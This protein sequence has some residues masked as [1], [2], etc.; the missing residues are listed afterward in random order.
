MMSFRILL[1]GLCIWGSLPVLGQEYRVEDIRIG[2]FVGERINTCIEYRVKSQDVEHLVEPFRHREETSLWQSEF[3]GKWLLGA[4]SSYEYCKDSI[5]LEQIKT[6]VQS[7][8][9]TQTSEGYIGNYKSEAQLTNWDIWGRKYSAL[10]LVAYYRL[11]GDKAALQAAMRSV[12]YLIKQLHEQR[13][14]I[15]RTGNYFGMASCSILE[16]VVY[17]YDITREKRYLDFAKNI[18]VGIE[19]KGS[20]QL[21]AKALK[22]VPVSQRSA[23]P[24]SWWSF[25]NGQKAYEMMSCYE[26]LIELGR[27]LNDPLYKEVAER[28]A[29]SIRQDE[30]NIA[31]SGAA[32][33]C[34][35]GG[36]GKQTLPAYHTMETCVTFTYMQFCNRLW[37]DT[38]NTLYIEEFER[39]MYNAL[40]ASMKHDGG[41]ISKYSPLEG[42]RLP[43]EEQCGMHINCCNANGPRG[44]ALIPKM[45]VAAKEDGV[46]FNLYVP[47]KVMLK[48]GKKN[49][50]ALKVAT[51]YPINGKVNIR[52]EPQRKEHFK[53]AL[54]I[55]SYVDGMKVFVNG[56]EQEVLH[57]GGYFYL[58][59]VWKRGDEVVLEFD[60]QTKVVKNHNHQAVVRGPLVFARDSRFGDGDV[61]EC[62][63]IQ[64]D[65][66]GVVQAT[67]CNNVSDSFAWITLEVPAVLGTDLEDTVNKTAKLVR[68]C[69]FASSG[70]DWTS[71][72][73]YRVWIP[74]TLHVMKEPYR[75]Y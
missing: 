5:L 21:I 16:P 49:A 9:Q 25:E 59:R 34:W 75:K 23:C 35:Y 53:L 39:T 73:R 46:F 31:G 13:I 74:Q 3:F 10:A 54:R 33:E 45:A 22:D 27:V 26:G 63:V 68:F 24:A 2:G 51:N 44:F 1:L 30:I 19:S 55:P 12:D 48:T 57:R 7:F 43:G 65:E 6:G 62:A 29:E 20:S 47:M 56:Q 18:V 8:M 41:Q 37:R 72:G 14:D 69:D 50:V 64:C 32:F 15:A 28:T 11:T 40:F 60:L 52:V 17:L 42:R 4:I 70:N 71:K 38:G 58:D 61:D 67:V 66:K 36:K